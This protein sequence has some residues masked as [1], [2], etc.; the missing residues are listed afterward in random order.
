MDVKNKRNCMIEELRDVQLTNNKLNAKIN[1]L[2]SVI[3]SLYAKQANLNNEYQ[4][5]IDALQKDNAEL[6][7]K[8]QESYETIE[9]LDFDNS[10]LKQELQYMDQLEDEKE[11]LQAESECRF[12]QAQELSTLLEN[13]TNELINTAREND[14]LTT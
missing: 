4:R 9:Q 1:S 2:E 11:A 6:H 7:K 8:I 14:N 5:E 13:V 3:D 12:E 10:E